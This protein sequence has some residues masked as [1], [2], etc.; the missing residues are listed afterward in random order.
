MTNNLEGG[1]NLS[2]SSELGGLISSE[3]AVRSIVKS[4][5]K[6]VFIDPKAYLDTE[7]QY[8]LQ[9]LYMEAGIPTKFADRQGK[10][11]TQRY[12]QILKQA[13]DNSLR[14]I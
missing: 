8:S 13:I 14:E 3:D 1:Q 7:K 4:S 6:D 2:L 5:M 12:V 11:E 10:A 9:S